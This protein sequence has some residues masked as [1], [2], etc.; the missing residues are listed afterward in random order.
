MI[1]RKKVAA[2][3]HASESTISFVFV[4]LITLDGCSFLAHCCHYYAI[5]CI[6]GILIVAF[7]LL[8]NAIESEETL[9]FR[10]SLFYSQQMSLGMCIY[11]MPEKKQMQ[12][13][14]LVAKYGTYT[15]AHQASDTIIRCQRRMRKIWTITAKWLPC[16]SDNQMTKSIG[17]ISQSTS[18]YFNVMSHEDVPSN[19]ELNSVVEWW[20]QNN[21]QNSTNSLTFD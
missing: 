17:F 4:F 7:F 3:A 13:L 14:I 8:Q 9:L 16:W 10:I 2:A 1:V 19:M 6:C 20:R 15:F 18:Q 5:R 11:K 21:L 12:K